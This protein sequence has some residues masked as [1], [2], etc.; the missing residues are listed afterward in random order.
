MSEQSEHDRALLEVMHDHVQNM[1]VATYDLTKAHTAAEMEKLRREISAEMRADLERATG[2]RFSDV[3]D[4]ILVWLRCI[5][6]PDVTVPSTPL[7]PV[8]MSPSALDPENPV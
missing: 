2:G 1:A 8:A 5:T 7:A 3:R 4:N 6:M